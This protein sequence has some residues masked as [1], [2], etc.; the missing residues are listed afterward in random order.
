MANF[1]EQNIVIIY[2]FYGL[3]FFCMGLFVWVESGRASTFRL[4]RA[5]GPLAGF[6][7]F[8]GL[9]EWIEMFQNMPTS[10]QLPEWV[11]AES[12]R[13]THLVLSFALLV[14]FGVRLVYANHQKAK[15]EKLFAILATGS[16]LIV[17]A[18]SIFITQRVYPVG[19]DD[20]LTAVDVLARYILGIP[21]ALLAAWAI[22]LEQQSFQRYGLTKSG[23]DLMRAALALIIYGLIGQIFVK[24]SFL[25]PSN[26]INSNLFVHTFG[27]P[28]QLFRAVAA[29][30]MAVFVVRAMRAFEFERQQNLLEANEARLAAQDHALA[31]QEET[32]QETERL[33]RDL[34]AAL[35]DLTLL[36]DFSRSMAESLD[37]DTI[38]HTAVSHIVPAL[39][40]IMGAAI[41]W[42]DGASSLSQMIGCDGFLNC[43]SGDCEDPVDVLGK[44]ILQQGKALRLHNGVYEPVDRHPQPKTCYNM[45][46][47]LMRQDQ[48]TGA[49]ILQV[50]TTNV[51]INLNEIKLLQT[52]VGQIS[53]ALEK[54]TLY[55]EVQAREMLRGELLHQV[56]SAQ[57][58][59]RQRIARELHDGTGQLL[60][61]MG[62]GFAA[63]AKSTQTNPQ[64]AQ[65]QLT[66]LKEMVNQAL[67]ELRD[68]IADLRPS[69][70]DDLGLIPALQSLV[71]TF[72]TRM[73]DSG[74]MLHTTL[75]VDG[76]AHRLHP[77]IETI[78][79]RIIQEALTNVVKH[80]NASEVQI[81]LDFRAPKLY[82]AI[83]DN[84]TGF[85]TKN[86]FNQ[87]ATS[88]SW[89]LLGMQERAS[90]VGGQF[91]IQSQVGNGTTINVC[92]PLLKDEGEGYA[93]NSTALSR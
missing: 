63:A 46:F 87:T 36:F 84:G 41:L 88:H 31:V 89:G 61:A 22:I 56:V 75:H 1:F 77:D 85:H 26:I 33:N 86:Y 72:E 8:H 2:F 68:L 79:F 15:H 24:E 57:E 13:L 28:V 6:G 27:I 64:L 5:M 80:A 37:R 42:Q 71:K 91:N 29:T 54:A 92:L 43:T 50:N 82:I 19:H 4:A 76:R 59:E 48:V 65:K 55:Q 32:R 10:V 47:P 83:T 23:N 49:L 34:T 38:V 39:S 52:V 70:L 17:W 67:K 40:W 69:V 16:L 58:Q 73:S 3:S 9:H 11:L 74:Q 25:F 51:P 20:L 35:Q 78:A 62:L 53:I 81:S 30:T 45:G 66:T 21:G 12:L 7:I 14:I 93:E 44:T 60:T 90:L 18:G